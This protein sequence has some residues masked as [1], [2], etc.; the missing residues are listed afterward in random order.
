[1]DELERFLMN[2]SVN[3]NNNPFGDPKEISYNGDTYYLHEDDVDTFEKLKEKV[4]PWHD[5]G[6][7]EDN[8]ECIVFCKGKPNAPFPSLVKRKN[9]KWSIIS[10]C[11]ATLDELQMEVELWMVVPEKTR[12]GGF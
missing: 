1:M 7:P 11:S 8:K 12:Q 10:D 9:G 2:S 4:F 6:F 3:P 5:N